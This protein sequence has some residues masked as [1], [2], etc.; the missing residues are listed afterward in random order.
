VTSPA[1]ANASRRYRSI[2]I[3][4]PIV[5]AIVL[6]ALIVLGYPI[7]GA[8]FCVGLFI[9]FVNSRMVI[10]SLARF[11]ESENPNKRA[12][13]SGVVQRLALVTLI[14]L[15]IGFTFRP[16]GFAVLAGL[17]LF[18]TMALGSTSA[19]MMREIRG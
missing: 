11:A 1:L 17:A 9:G 16:E 3:V 15:G 10:S 12:L 8:T 5:G 6:V 13:M 2:L 19:S 14:A 18:Q 4:C 7:A